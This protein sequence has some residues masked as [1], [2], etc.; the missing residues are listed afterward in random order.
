MTEKD[1]FEVVGRFY[2]EM[3]ETQE[4]LQTMQQSLTEKDRQ[5]AALRKQNEPEGK[6]DDNS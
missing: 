3:R 4:L 1:L 6:E 2:M 5:I